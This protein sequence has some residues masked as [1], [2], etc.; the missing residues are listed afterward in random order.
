MHWEAALIAVSILGISTISDR[1]L[2]AST[3]LWKLC[4]IEVWPRLWRALWLTGWYQSCARGWSS[5]T[6]PLVRQSKQPNPP[7]QDWLL[8]LLSSQESVTHGEDSASEDS[9]TKIHPYV[10]EMII[11][12]FVHTFWLMGE[13]GGG[14]GGSY[15]GSGSSSG[16]ETGSLSWESW[17]FSNSWQS[18]CLSIPSAEMIGMSRHTWVE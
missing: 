4:I 2:M 9:F 14:G 5:P 13:G 17:L 12:K 18:F 3:F 10:T 8:M 7:D 1:K 16:F 15:G 11:H 6:S